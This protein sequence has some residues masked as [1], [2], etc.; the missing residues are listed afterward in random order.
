[1]SIQDEVGALVAKAEGAD[2][3]AQNEPTMP[4]TA[5]VSLPTVPQ[6]ETYRYDG[7]C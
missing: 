5:D 6:V 1:M 7:D 4:V 3:Q 2:S